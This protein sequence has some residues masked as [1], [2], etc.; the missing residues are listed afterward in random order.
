MQRRTQ[1]WVLTHPRLHNK[2]VARTA[3]PPAPPSP[4]SLTSLIE[5]H[6]PASCSS[7]T[8]LATDTMPWPS[9]S[10]GPV[11]GSGSPAPRAVTLFRKCTTASSAAGPSGADSFARTL[12][13]IPRKLEASASDRCPGASERGSGSSCGQRNH[14]LLAWLL[15]RDLPGITL[16]PH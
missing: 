1:R 2:L 9:C 8:K 7:R 5:S 6:A 14:L 11:K 10:Q 12:S 4:A 13:R 16:G 3:S 15:G